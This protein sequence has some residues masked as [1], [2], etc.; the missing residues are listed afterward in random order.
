MNKIAASAELLGPQFRISAFPQ[1]QQVM[2]QAPEQT[3]VQQLPDS[4]AGLELKMRKDEAAWKREEIAPNTAP[5]KERTQE[6]TSVW[7]PPEGVMGVAAQ[8]VE[9]LLD[10]KKRRN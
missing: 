1:Q 4:Q 8:C 5:F 6:F 2:L 10:V 3:L 7:P 9:D